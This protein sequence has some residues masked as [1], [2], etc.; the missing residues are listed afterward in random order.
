METKLDFSMK[1][2]AHHGDGTLVSIRTARNDLNVDDVTGSGSSDI[3]KTSVQDQRAYIFLGEPM[4]IVHELAFFAVVSTANFTP[5]GYSW[6]RSHPLFLPSG[7]LLSQSRRLHETSLLEMNLT[8]APRL[9][10]PPNALHTSS[11]SR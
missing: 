8:T 5:R 4:S 6:F 10:V 7:N 11:Y 2:A 1:S 3:E 9:G